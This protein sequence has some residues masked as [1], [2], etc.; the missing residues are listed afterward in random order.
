MAQQDP[1]GLLARSRV[2]DDRPTGSNLFQRCRVRLRRPTGAVRRSVRVVD[3]R[4]QEPRVEHGPGGIPHHLGLDEL[5]RLAV[6][7]V[8]GGEPRPGQHR[9]KGYEDHQPRH[10]LHV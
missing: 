1:S 8:A 5:Q 10:R 2:V 4:R 6:H 3:L 7:A 9:D